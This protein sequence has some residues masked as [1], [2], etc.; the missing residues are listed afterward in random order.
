MIYWGLMYFCMFAQV[1]SIN[2][3]YEKD[4]I[5]VADQNAKDDYRNLQC[6]I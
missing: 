1:N 4:F 5:L 2:A 3:L 6:Y